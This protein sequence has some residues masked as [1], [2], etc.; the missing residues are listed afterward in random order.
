MKKQIMSVIFALIVGVPCSAKGIE[1]LDALK[2]PVDQVLGILQDPHYQDAARK[3]AQR[4]KIWETIGQAFD[5]PVMAKLALARNWKKFTVQQRKEFT[6]LFAELLEST[7]VDKIQGGYEEEKVLYLGQKMVSDSKAR[8]TTKILRSGVDIPI[9]YSMLK[10]N[11]VW[12][13]YDVNIEG[14]SL[15]KNYRTQFNNILAKDSQ[16]QLIER[17]KHK[18]ELQRK[19][20]TKKN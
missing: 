17:L 19:N 9:V 7:Y 3:D 13:V 11:D 16:A 2:A 5:F 10:R 1:P 20:R 8:V 12:R 14:V 18:I 4:E 15:I 6:G